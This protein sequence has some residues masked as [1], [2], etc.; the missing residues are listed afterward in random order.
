MEIIKK[1][2]LFIILYSILIIIGLIVI[3]FSF[4]NY[5]YY[6]EDIAKI[7]SVKDEKVSTKTVSFGY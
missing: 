2:K 6:D 1:N 3:I 5:K 4:N 7:V